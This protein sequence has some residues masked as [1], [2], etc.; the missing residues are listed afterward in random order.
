V[1]V[2]MPD[3]GW[4][5]VDPTLVV[6]PQRLEQNPDGS[7]LN[8]S[9]AGAIPV[10]KRLT[11]MLEAANLKWEAWFTGYSFA[12]QKELMAQLGVDTA[13][14][15]WKTILLLVSLTLLVLALFLRFFLHRLRPEKKDPVA[16]AYTLFCKRLACIGL[17][18]PPNLGPVD[19]LNH[20]KVLRPDLADNART[21]TDLYVQIRF[22][23]THSN[24]LTKQL[25]TH[26]RQF[27]PSGRAKTPS[28]KWNSH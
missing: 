2:F 17:V 16:E 8:S 12:S 1:E 5:R 11:F 14:G 21:I 4:V 22:A 6:A 26:V 24:S 18:R 20:V 7:F 9:G 10:H 27:K 15:Q 25:I 28:H 3:T 19:F 23:K 13:R